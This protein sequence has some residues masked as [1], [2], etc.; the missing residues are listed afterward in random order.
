MCVMNAKQ[1]TTG[2][3]TY[4]GSSCELKRVLVL[5]AIGGV[6]PCMEIPAIHEWK[7][8]SSDPLNIS[9]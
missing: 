7:E 5:H 4:H 1:V 9:L 6:L 8:F 2:A 3:F